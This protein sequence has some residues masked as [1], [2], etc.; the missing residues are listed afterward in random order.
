MNIIFYINPIVKKIQLDEK[1][2][3]DIKYSIQNDPNGK[4]E[5]P[6][7]QQKFS[8]SF[9]L[10]EHFLND[11]NDYNVLC[12]LDTNK[13]RNGFPGFDILQRINMIDDQN[14]IIKKN[15]VIYVAL[16]SIK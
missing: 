7:C 13:I 4:Y 12:S 11:H 1:L 5:C 15:I 16:N 8:N 10:G 3:T 9:I 6:I 14:N 2:S